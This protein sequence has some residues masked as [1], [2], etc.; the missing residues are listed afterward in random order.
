MCAIM[1]PPST[2]DVV[3]APLDGSHLAAEALPA[4]ASYAREAGCRLVLLHVLP[5]EDPAK[6]HGAREHQVRHSQME[7]YLQGLKRVLGKTG[8]VEIETRVEDGE[9]VAKILEVAHSLGR[10][11]LVL[12][13]SGM[14]AVKYPDEPP[15]GT[16]YTRIA[17]DWNGPL[18]R[19]N[20]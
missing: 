2:Y 17:A 10:V 12:T 13:D 8:G 6:P 15:S 11:I 16:V 19:V 18:L 9:P 20:V 5:P 1:N 3:L 14:S 4:A 7:A